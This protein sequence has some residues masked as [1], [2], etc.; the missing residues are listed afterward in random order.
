MGGLPTAARFNARDAALEV[1]GGKAELAPLREARSLLLDSTL[2]HI[3]ICKLQRSSGRLVIDAEGSGAAAARLAVSPLLAPPSTCQC[4]HCDAVT[5]ISPPQV[6]IPPRPR[7]N[8]TF[9]MVARAAVLVVLALAAVS[10][11]AQSECRRV[12]WCSGGVRAAAP[13]PNCRTAALC[14]PKMLADPARPPRASPPTPPTRLYFCS[15]FCV[16]PDIRGAAG[17]HHRQHC[18]AVWRVAE[19]VGPLP[20]PPSTRL[21]L[22]P[23]SLLPTCAAAAAAAATAPPNSTP[24]SPLLVLLTAGALESALQ[25]C[26]TGYTPGTFL[27]VNQQI[28]LPPW[29]VACNYVKSTSESA[30]PPLPPLPP[31]PRTC[32]ALVCQ[33]RPPPSPSPPLRPTLAPQV[34]TPTPASTTPSSRATP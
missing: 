1:V 24:P 16:V 34:R 15:H 11:R 25:V 6:E 27:Q 20:A 26:V 10:V 29:E 13:T 22:R 4:A 30:L 17:R 5:L 9:I 19:C 18:N 21:P 28:C 32:C 23:P 3:F 12:L 8:R 14:G 2:P 7:S 33:A 31:P